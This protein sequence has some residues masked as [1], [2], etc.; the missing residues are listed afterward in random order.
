MIA[1]L[2]IITGLTLFTVGVLIGY[3]VGHE[4]GRAAAYRAV[5]EWQANQDRIRRTYGPR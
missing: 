1:V 5:S 3:V 4:D 2:V